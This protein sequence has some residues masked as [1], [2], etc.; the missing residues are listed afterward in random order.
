MAIAEITVI[1]VGTASTSLSA[2]VADI[3]RYG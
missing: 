2:Y 1:P 3:H